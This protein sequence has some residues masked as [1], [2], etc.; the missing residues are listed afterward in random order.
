LRSGAFWFYYKLGLGHHRVLQQLALDEV[1][2]NRLLK[3]QGT[4]CRFT[5]IYHH[6]RCSAT[7]KNSFRV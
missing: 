5:K 1:A 7:D 4:I 6:Y 2:K 3:I